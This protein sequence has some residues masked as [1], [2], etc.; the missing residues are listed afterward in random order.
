MDAELL[1]TPAAGLPP[2]PIPD[3]GKTALFL[4][5]DGTLLDLA[6]TPQA[7]VVDPG[8]PALLDQLRR[9]TGGAL[10][11]VSGRSLDSLDRLL[12]PLLL[13]AAGLHGGQWRLGNQ[14]GSLPPPPPSF[15]QVTTELST[16]AAAHPGITI[17]NKALAL[18]VHTRLAPHWAEAAAG[19]ARAA[20]ARLGSG[21]RLQYGSNVVELVPVEATKGN[22]IARLMERA[23]FAGRQPVF[24]G[25][26]LTDESGFTQVTAQG[27]FGI[28]VGPERPTAARHRLASVGALRGW[29]ASLAGGLPSTL[30][31]GVP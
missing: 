23:P 20:L 8:L 11:L 18:A 14:R 12:A 22:G 31:G 29:L 27:G 16:F 10:A 5:V 26:D 17:E 15:A 6:A 4:D 21:Y 1:I 19:A 30:S 25:D 9:A 13:D 3:V 28:L 7:V 2:P 24:A